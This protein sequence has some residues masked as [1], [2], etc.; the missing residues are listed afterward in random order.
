MS[1]EEVQLSSF[2]LARYTGH[3]L[4][5]NYNESRTVLS[6]DQNISIQFM[7]SEDYRMF[8]EMI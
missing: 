6:E 8:F 1:S 4:S 5:K 2:E 7:W 3:I